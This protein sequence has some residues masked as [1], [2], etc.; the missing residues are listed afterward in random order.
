METVHLSGLS[1]VFSVVVFHCNIFCFSTCVSTNSLV[2]MRVICLNIWLL[3]NYSNNSG[4]LFCAF[5]FIFTYSVVSFMFFK[6]YRC[7]F[8]LPDFSEDVFKSLIFFALCCNYIVFVPFMFFKAYFSCW[9]CQR[10]YF[11][12]RLF[13]LIITFFFNFFR[14]LQSLSLLFFHKVTLEVFWKDEG[15]HE[16]RKTERRLVMTKSY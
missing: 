10:V 16:R 4:L 8:L 1:W 13:S 6:A 14:V 2:S 9:T 11:R 3:R 7:H 5:S 15:S 12:L